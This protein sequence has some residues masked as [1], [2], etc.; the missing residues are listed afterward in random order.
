MWP[1]HSRSTSRINI[2]SDCLTGHN[3]YVRFNGV[4]HGF[5]LWVNG[6]RVGYSEDSYVPAEFDIT[7]YLVEG[8]NVMA[9]QV[10]RFTS[11]SFLECQ[12]YW[13]LTGI[14]RHCFIWAAPKTQI[15]DYFFTTDL[16]N[17]YVNAKANVKVTVENAYL[18][19]E[20]NLLEAKIMNGNTMVAKLTTP[21]VGRY[22]KFVAKSEINGNPWTS[23]AEI[24][25]QAESYTT[26]IQQVEVDKQQNTAV[27]YDL[28]GRRINGHL[29]HQPKGIYISNG[30]KVVK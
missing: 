1:I 24:G 6:Q 28:N 30:H 19:S 22:L 9:L 13:R 7:K 23:A 17:Q 14:Q 12:D 15:R 18:L 26:A 20:G 8:D 11:G 29:A 25:I 4:G 3:V 27:V 5:Y 21:T 16:D 10:Y 2:T